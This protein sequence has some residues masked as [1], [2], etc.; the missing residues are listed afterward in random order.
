VLYIPP[1]PS[2]TATPKPECS[3]ADQD[4]AEQKVKSFESGWRREIE[5]ERAKILAQNVPDGVEN[6]EARLGQIE[7]QY[8]FPKRCKAAVV[9]ASYA[10]QI[11]YSIPGTPSKSK[12]VARRRTIGCGK[13]LGMWV[14]H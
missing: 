6:S 13:V 3:D 8:A 1:T 11:N 2:P 12:T 4:R 5:S 9:T 7:F 14:C 10:W